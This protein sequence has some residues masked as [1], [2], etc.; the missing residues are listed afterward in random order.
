MSPRVVAAIDL[1]A[2][3]GRVV[4]GLVDLGDRGASIELVEIHRFPNELVERDGHLRWAFDELYA[5]VLVGLAELGRSYPNAE[6]IGIDTWG[7]DYGLIGE[8]GRLLADPIAYRDPRTDAVIE[9]VHQL[10]SAEEL[11]EINGLQFLPFTTLYQLM[12]ERQGPHL[13]QAANALLLPDLL[14]HRL[15][16][17]ARTE[18][19]NASTTGLLDVRTRAWSLLLIERLGVPPGL[20][21]PIEAPGARRGELLPGIARRLGLRPGV[22]VITVASHDTASAVAAIPATSPDVAFISSGTWS[23]VGVELRAPVVTPQSRKANFTNEAGVDGRTRFLRNVGGLWLLE[24]CLGAW[25]ADGD[26]WDYETLVD[27]ARSLPPGGPTVDVDDASFIAPGDMPARIR[28]AVESAGARL[29]GPVA[30]LDSPAAFARC[31]FD[32]LAAAYSVAITQAAALSS[33]SVD[34]VHIVGG[35]SRNELLC[36]L[37]ADACRRPVIAGPAEAT[38]LGNVIIQARALDARLQSLDEARTMLAADPA[39][40]R[41]EPASP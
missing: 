29:P 20:F 11:Y 33:R 18:L 25:S 31:I 14:A 12:A 28:H 32:S 19:T 9:H 1:G 13:E 40:R 16:G 8:D 6:S 38:A 41:F 24:E 36:Q 26:R 22:A 39:M 37:T 27:A 3:S 4:A 2:T 17:V 10:V 30:A 35:G 5:E 34:T 23:L 15:T 7:V 21:P